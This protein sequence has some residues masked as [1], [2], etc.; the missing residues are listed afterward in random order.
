MRIALVTLACL[1]WV[2]T[3]GATEGA[4]N[5]A[6]IASRSESKEATAGE[7]GSPSEGTGSSA[8]KLPT[9]EEA[10]EAFL[11]GRR[12]ISEGAWTDAEERFLFAVRVKNTPGLRYYIGYCR[13]KQGL[14]VE[15]LSSYRLAA[16]LL[17][18]QEAPDVDEMVPVAIERV[19]G[20]LPVLILYDVPSSA[21]L[22]FDGARRPLSQQFHANPGVHRVLIEQDGYKPFETAVD[23]VPGEK[24]R[25]QVKLE[26]IEV[27]SEE[28][29]DDG[30]TSSSLELRKIVFWSSTGV[31]ALGLGAGVTGAVLFSSTKR[32]L[33]ELNSEADEI[34]GE[35][36]ASC[37][38]PSSSLEQVCEDLARGAKRKNTMGNLMVGGFVGAGV[39]AAGALVT[40]FFWPEAPVRVDVGLSGGGSSFWVS[41][42]F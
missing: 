20:L 39:G 33:R 25:I 24:S 32:G 6:G 21:R 8:E 19:S 42:Q 34:S 5:S 17:E 11:L 30:R 18:T 35:E 1:L 14:L 41:G 37:V 23:L 13:E 38:R 12:L 31:A 16:D 36:D 7:A 9:I 15:A 10:R 4:S 40:H 29:A 27:G 28:F 2:Q 22:T 26:P 3:L